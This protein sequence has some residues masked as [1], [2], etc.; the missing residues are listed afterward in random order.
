[1]WWIFIKRLVTTRNG[2][3]WLVALCWAISARGQD[4]N[5]VAL[6]TGASFAASYN[7]WFELGC[8]KRGLVPVNRAVGG[9]AIADAANRMQMED[10]YTVDELDDVA[11][12]VIM[13]VHNQLVFDSA[14]TA[15]DYRLYE[16]PMERSDYVKA[17]DYVIKR[18]MADCYAL[19]DN[20]NSK[21][22]GTAHGKPPVIVLCTH[23]NDSRTVYNASVRKLSSHWGL[24]LVEFDKYI[25]FSKNQKH[26]ITNQQQSLLFAKDTQTYDGETYGFHPLQGKDEYIQKR[27]AA[28]FGDLLEKVIY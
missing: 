10:L 22:Y 2:F 14:V 1:M 28:I 7:G 27:M 6:L 5:R 23:W 13:Q 24:P 21:Y 26:P 12:F 16:F 15:K 11:V 25:G 9:E 8:E 3:V 4:G 17:Y 19:K 20:K 18:Y